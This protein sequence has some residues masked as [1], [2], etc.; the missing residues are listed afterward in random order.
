MLLDARVDK[1]L[2]GMKISKALE[3]VPVS[4]ST[5][6]ENYAAFV[7]PDDKTKDFIEYE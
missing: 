1:C 2:D 5:D 6:N 4:R 3:N 7:I